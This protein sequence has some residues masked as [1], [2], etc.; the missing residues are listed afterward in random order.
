MTRDPWFS[1]FSRKVGLPAARVPGVRK[2]QVQVPLGD[3][4]LTEATH[5][6]PV[7]QDRAPLVLVR[8]PYG[9]F[10]FNLLVG[11]F[12]AHQGFQVLIQASRG[13][14]GSQGAFD[15]PFGCEIADGAATV[16]WLVKQP[17]YPGTFMTF[18]DSYLGWAQIALAEH[19]GDSLAAMVLR[20][21]PSSL[22]DMVWPGGNL[23]LRAGLS[24]SAMAQR[25]PT[26]GVKTALREKS[27][28]AKVTKAGTQAPLQT[29]YLGASNGPIGFWEDWLSHPTRDDY[30]AR[31]EIAKNLDS[32]TCPVLVQGGWY[33][34]FLEDS[35]GQYARLTSSGAPVELQLGPWT[36]GDMLTKGL[37]ASFTD[38]TAFL[39]EVAGL[40]KR[41]GTPRPVR[42]LEI[43]SGAD[44]HLDRWAA[45]PVA[46]RTWHL[47]PGSLTSTAADTG[48]TSFRYDPADPTPQVG[49]AGND[50][51][52]GSRD[53]TDLEKRADVVTFTTEP[54]PADLHLLGAPQI[55]LTFGSDRTDTAVF[56]RLCEVKPDGTSFNITD[57]I[58]QLRA[59]NRTADA[60]DPG[61]T[62]TWDL[63]VTLPPTCIAISAGNRLRLQVSSGA[64][65]LYA[66]HPG[67][68]E[69]VGTATEYLPASQTVHH[70]GATLTLPVR[71]VTAQG[72]TP[73]RS[74]EPASA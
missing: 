8:T 23:F 6:T 26:L 29:S 3:G 59:A 52:S 9:R 41:P 61:S 10:L 54:L 34:L 57:R 72:A 64:Y 12:L 47:A 50:K 5:W 15:D 49:G 62:S 48:T 14:D 42:L 13:T 11:R 16:D 21:A 56:L 68:A 32:V 27:Q 4:V 31:L 28:L 7:G 40:E 44:V 43:N 73:L 18:G 20:V 53:N 65:P 45:D 19:A 63:T 39:R 38:A 17:F 67:T 33:D 2:A 58:V 66:R 51:A 1:L 36:H 55:A 46:T 71:D 60:S 35:L 37:G 25:D 70:T 22:Y 69:P 24:W 74:V 30:W